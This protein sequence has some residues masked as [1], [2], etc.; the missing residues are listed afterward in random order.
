MTRV[1]IVEDHRLFAES[2]ELALGMEGHEVHR[3]LVPTCGA[4]AGGLLTSVLRVRPRVVLLDLDLGTAGSGSRLVQPLARAGCG[5]IVVTGCGD[6]ARWGECLRYGA[7]GVLEKTAPL[8]SILAAIRLTGEGRAVLSRE[9]RERLLLLFHQEK[10]ELQVVR[11]RLER[12][13]AREAQVLERLMDGRTVREIAHEAVVS[14]ATV[15]TQ[16]KAVLSKLE[17]S[18]QLAAVGMAHRA[19]WRS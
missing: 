10:Q 14:E 5:V 8:N 3:V 17:V 16:V 4:P 13:T 18:S 19:R 12:L 15:R 6:L 7:R 11:D 2:L 1:A 9:E